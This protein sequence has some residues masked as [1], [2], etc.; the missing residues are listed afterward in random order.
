MGYYLNPSTR[1][2]LLC[3]WVLL[4]SIPFQT[5]AQHPRR[6]TSVR[7]SQNPPSSFR[8]ASGQIALRIP[9]ELSNNFILLQVQ[10]N[11]SQPLWFI[12]DTGASASLIDAQLVKKLNLRTR[13]KAQGT[14][15][16]GA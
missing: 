5:A 14:A 13:G 2:I 4:F 15:G 1:V 6:G 16:G 10:V 11:D 12:F 7:K 3:V 9:F 8:F